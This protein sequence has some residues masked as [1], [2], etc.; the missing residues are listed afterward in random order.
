M[1]KDIIDGY[2]KE[3]CKEMFALSSKSEKSLNLFVR[4][5][6][7]SNGVITCVKFMYIP[8]FSPFMTY[9]DIKRNTEIIIKRKPEPFLVEYGIGLSPWITIPVHVSTLRKFKEE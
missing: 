7:D 4:I 6:V 8:S 5:R 2:G 3:R 1:T 9:E